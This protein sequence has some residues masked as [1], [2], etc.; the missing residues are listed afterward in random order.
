[1]DQAPEGNCRLARTAV[2]EDVYH[3]ANCQPEYV[4]TPDNW[5]EFTFTTPSKEMKNTPLPSSWVLETNET[6]GAAKHREKRK[7]ASEA[8][9]TKRRMVIRGEWSYFWGFYGSSL[10]WSRGSRDFPKEVNYI[11]KTPVMG[12]RTVG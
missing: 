1:M 2:L 5:K 12:A 8:R 3:A 10:R 11:A 7:L 4:S 9:R 6:L